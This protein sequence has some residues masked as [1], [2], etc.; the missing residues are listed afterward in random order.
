MI[1]AG[2]PPAIYILGMSLLTKLFAPTTEPSP[3][4]TPMPITHEAP[5]QTSSPITTG[6]AVT[7]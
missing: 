7:P 5:I 1:F 4:L 6:F 2:L 3:I